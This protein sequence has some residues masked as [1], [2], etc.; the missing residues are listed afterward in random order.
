VTQPAFASM[1]VEARFRTIVSILRSAVVSVMA[2]A[3]GCESSAR[4]V[5]RERAIARTAAQ[6][7]ATHQWRHEVG[8]DSVQMRGDTTI[9]WVSPRN[10]MA[11]D[12]PQAVVHVVPGGRVT[13]VQWIMGG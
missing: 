10:W 1:Y 7:T 4:A 11:T 9:V 8:V 5:E 13:G 3:L 12:A 6:D 2:V